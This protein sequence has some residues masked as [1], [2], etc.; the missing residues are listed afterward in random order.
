MWGCKGVSYDDII[1]SIEKPVEKIEE[2]FN[3]SLDSNIEEIIFNNIK[4]F[5]SYL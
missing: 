2:F 4:T 1:T 3:E 5:K